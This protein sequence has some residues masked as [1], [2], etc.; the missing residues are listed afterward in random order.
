M[1]KAVFVDF[2]STLYSHKTNRIPESAALAVNKL[3]ENDI[4]VFICSGRSL[5]EM[6]NFDL[7]SITID[8]MIANNGQLA[9]DQK[10]NILYRHPISGE[11]KDKLVSIFKDKK[12][13]IFFNCEKYLFASFIN[14]KVRKTQS[15]INSPEPMVKEYE[16]EN[17]YMVSCFLSNDSELEKIMELKD[18][19]S[20]TYWHDGA[21][22][23]VTK[24][25][26][27]AKG[28]EE[29]INL[30]GIKK[31]ETMGIGDSEN[32]IDMLEYCEIGVAVGNAKDSVKQAADYISDDIDEDG[33]YNAVKHFNLI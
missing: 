16:D 13:P 21:V 28:I 11:L 19:A 12:I 4:K 10:N 25:A 5:Y 9:Y 2:D 6:D 17:F 31:E 27:K 32:D 3:R 23:I 14:E 33:L 18:L 22:D 7:T 26:S 20:I 1:I 29:I 24:D 30:F 15:D 8:G